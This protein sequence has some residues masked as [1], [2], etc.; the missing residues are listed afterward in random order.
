MSLSD[1]RKIL[2]GGAA[3]VAL[4]GCG[5][6]PVYGS[7]GAGQAL[8]G[9]VRLDDPV[10]RADFQLVQAVEDLLGRPENERFT[11]SYTVTQETVGAGRLQG[12]G[13]TRFQ[14]FGTLAYSVTEV[15]TGI[16]RAQ[17]SVSGNTAYSSTGTQLATQT[18]AED[19][20]AR[21]MRMLAE[22]LVTRLFVEPGL[23]GA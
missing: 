13:D 18:A 21:L 20:E 16:L 3:L 14:I 10:T 4:A 22:S 11:L 9:A 12:F 17:G 7:G 8:R 19:A 15:A 2:L 6:R 5:F 1:R 23:Q